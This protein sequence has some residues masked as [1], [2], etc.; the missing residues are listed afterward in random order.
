MFMNSSLVA[1]IALGLAASLSACGGGEPKS[2]TTP[3]TSASA[4]PSPTS[5]TGAGGPPADWES[6]FTPAELTAAQVAMDTWE[7][8]S[9]LSTA[10]YKQGK[11]T[12]GAK[13]TL[14]KY[15]FWWQRDI[16]DLGETY[17]KGGLRLVE[18]VEPLWSYAKSVRLNKDGTGDVVIVQCTDYQPLRYTRNGSPQKINKPKHLVTPLM[19]T[20]T[21]PDDEHGWMY[22]KAQ[23][24]DRTSCAAE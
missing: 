12:P 5:I 8:Y 15:D 9:L 23:L 24:K 2:D 6:K 20:M 7:E 11:L 10:I 22:Y 13:A 19:V 14:Q 21:K 3:S 4:S 18:D 17:D 1:T 16:V